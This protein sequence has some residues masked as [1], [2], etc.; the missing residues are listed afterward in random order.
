MTSPSRQEDPRSHQPAS[1]PQG[2]LQ[3]AGDHV[4][5]G[6]LL[7]EEVIHVP[8]GKNRLQFAVMVAL[9]VFL[10]IIF[11]VPGALQTSLLGTGQQD[12]DVLAY[13]DPAGRRTVLSVSEYQ[14]A[15]NGFSEVFEIFEILKL[16]LGIQ[17]RTLSDESAARLIVLDGEAR[18]AGIVISDAELAQFLQELQVDAATW[19]AITARSGGP[20]VME[21]NLKKVLGIRRYIDLLAQLARI[22]D[23]AA[24]EKRWASEHEE[25]SFEYVQVPIA[26]LVE[27]AKAEA[28]GDAALEAWFAAKSEAEQAPFLE[29]ARFR[30]TFA[31]FRDAAATPAEGLLERFPDTSTDAPDVRAQAYY[32]QVF[33]SRFAREIDPAEV[34]PEGQE[35]PTPYLS[36]EE[37][38]ERALVEAPVYFALQNWRADLE[39]RLA[40]GATLDLAAE[41]ESLGLAVVR[42]EEPATLADLRAREDLGDFA[43]GPVASTEP[44]KVAARVLADSEGLVVVRTDERLEPSLPAFAAIRE[45]V[46]ESWAENRAGELA[47]EKL[48]GLRKGF[49]LVPVED[50]KDEL[51]VEDE[52][53]ATESYKAS[54]DAFRAAVEAAGY[55]LETRPWLDKSGQPTEDPDA[56]KPAHQFLAQQRLFGELDEGE[57]PAAALDRQ[58]QNAYLVRLAGKRPIDLAR[59]TPQVYNNYKSQSESEPGSQLRSYLMSTEFDDRYAIEWLGRRESEEPTED[60][61]D[62]VDGDGSA[63]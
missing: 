20:G 63:Q 49:E 22:P 39:T 29:P 25:I 38:K 59:M 18:A 32:D 9:L 47:L 23:P 27:A 8:K 35:P 53:P 42:I 3:A 4:E 16:F 34:V 2:A 60:G 51:A 52:P 24:I 58:K 46:L 62:G 13:Q 30:A 45:R 55:A 40:S 54:A 17:E 11:L 5:E 14:R 61:A 44:G 41:A 15:R 19:R 31:A 7:G 12:E 26:G 37:V 10:T 21:P 33:F 43:I 48:E 57:V 6:G 1:T 56:A 28:P 36:F 50:P